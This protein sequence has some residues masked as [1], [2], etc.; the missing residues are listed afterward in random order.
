[1]PDSSSILGGTTGVGIFDFGFDFPNDSG[2]RGFT[3]TE[4]ISIVLSGT[5]AQNPLN[6]LSFADPNSVG[7]YAGVLIRG[8]NGTQN[9]K[10]QSGAPMVANPEASTLILGGMV[11]LLGVGYGWNR[12]QR[13]TA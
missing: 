7:Q 5:E 4:T 13:T 6:Y 10:L 2:R 3:G 12:R 9:A 8:I 1:L 11:S